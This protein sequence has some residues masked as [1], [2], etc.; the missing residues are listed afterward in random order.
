MNTIKRSWLNRL[1]RPSAFVAGAFLS[2]TV[3]CDVPNVNLRFGGYDD[4]DYGYVIVDDY[5]YDYC[6]DDYYYDWFWW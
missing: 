6:C 1:I 5:D 4:D 2:A 3:V